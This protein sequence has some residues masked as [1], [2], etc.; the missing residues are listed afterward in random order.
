MKSLA[1]FKTHFIEDSVI[2]EYIKLN[3]SNDIETILFIDNHTGFIKNKS[4]VP[5]KNI[6]FNGKDINCFLFDLNIFKSMNLPYYTDITDNEDLGK[7][8]WYNSDYPAYI[9]KKYFPGYD[10][11]WSIEYDVFC[12][13]KSYSEF[14]NNYTQNESDLIVSD[15]R[16]FKNSDEVWYW[17]DKSEWIYKN[18]EKFGSFFPVFRLSSN[19]IDYLYKR[20]QEHAAEFEKVKYNPNNRWVFCES[21]VP[22]ELSN[23]GF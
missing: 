14:F 20:R 12:N 2:S 9:V 19:A 16:S 1:F 22:T 10:Y 6:N 5:I 23:A 7:A 8:I 17:N 18:I 21:F 3:S 13:G 11:Y 15:Y 4:D